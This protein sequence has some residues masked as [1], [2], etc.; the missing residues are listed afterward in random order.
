MESSPAI[1]IRFPTRSFLYLDSIY[2]FLF[3]FFFLYI[4]TSDLYNQPDFNNHGVD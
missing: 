2:P 1:N 3:P 4:D